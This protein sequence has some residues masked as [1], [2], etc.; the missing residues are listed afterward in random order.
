[1]PREEH[2]MK[3][4]L[5]AFLFAAILCMFNIVPALASEPV[6]GGTATTGGN[7]H[8]IWDE[9]ENGDSWVRQNADE[10]T[11]DDA[12]SW[13]DRKGG[14]VVE[15]CAH[16]LKPVCVVGFILCVILMVAGAVGNKKLLVGG[17]VGLFICGLCYTF[18]TSPVQIM[19]AF[20][21]FVKA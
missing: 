14:Q 12:S 11:V 6:G 2:I 13:V 7:S 5:I 10:V 3:K 18:A 16:F 17:L 1:M 15:L 9:S 21:S 8:I 4:N 19:N 20:A